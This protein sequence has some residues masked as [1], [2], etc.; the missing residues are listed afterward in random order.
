MANTLRRHSENFNE[1]MSE[2]KVHEGRRLEMYRD[3]MGNWT[4]GYGHLA[5]YLVDE[6]GTGYRITQMDAEYLLMNDLE[7]A[8]YECLQFYWFE[9]LTPIRQRVIA[10]VVFNVGITRFKKFKNTIKA[11]KAKDWKK[12]GDELVDSLWYRQVKSRGI[13]LVKKW[14]IDQ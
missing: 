12:A 8:I 4:I 1:L 7:T 10:N 2:I 13:D 11:I 6:Y 14:R 9:D 3:T 5:N